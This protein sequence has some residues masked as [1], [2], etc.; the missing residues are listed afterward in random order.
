MVSNRKFSEG[1]IF[2]TFSYLC[3]H[4]INIDSKP[5]NHKI[6]DKKIQARGEKT[7]NKFEVWYGEMLL[8]I[9]EA[10]NK[11]EARQKMEELKLIAV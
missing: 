8:G 7:M 2:C 3:I 1:H 5:N 10:E 11:D 4:T 6:Q 9:I